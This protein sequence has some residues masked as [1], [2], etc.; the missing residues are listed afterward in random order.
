MRQIG[1]QNA[2]TV[3]FLLDPASGQFYFIEMNTRIQVEHPVTEMVTNVDL[4][5][6]QVQ[7][8][9]GDSLSNV[10]PADVSLREHAIECRIVA[11]DPE[12]FAPSAGRIS[13]FHLP[14]GTGV[15]V[16]AAAYAEAVIPPYYDSLIA[17][18]IVRGRNREE[19]VA[20][21]ARALEMFVV[22][23]VQTSISL[24]RRIMGDADFRAGTYDTHFMERFL[25]TPVPV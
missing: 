4:I 2:G 19:A 16:D 1:Y 9:A 5:K 20:R 14:G 15:R 3:E 8:A 13:V 17:K 7:L 24:H 6:A 10:V 25:R 22:E 11:E 18:L 12:T 21:M 23:G